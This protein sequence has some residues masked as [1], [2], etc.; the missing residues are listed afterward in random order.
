MMPVSKY[1]HPKNITLG[2]LNNPINA[3]YG[4]ISIQLV[5]HQSALTAYQRQPQFGIIAEKAYRLSVKYHGPDHS[6]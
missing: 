5:T 6:F 4:T 3:Q 2:W 1:E